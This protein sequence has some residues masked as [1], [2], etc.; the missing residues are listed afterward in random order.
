M[1]ENHANGSGPKMFNW[2]EM[3]DCIGEPVCK[4]VNVVWSISPLTKI[5]KCQEAYLD[6]K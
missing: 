1:G 5:A 3:N 2:A 6:R 4:G